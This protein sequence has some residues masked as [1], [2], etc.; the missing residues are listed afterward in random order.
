MIPV[1]SLELQNFALSTD[2]QHIAWLKIDC[3]GSAVNRL[4]ADVLQELARV[5][6]YL[7][8]QVPNGLV[9]YSGKPAGFIAGADI[10]E[11]AELDN[12]QKGQALVTRG[13]RLFNKLAKLPYPTLALIQGHCLGGGLE[14]ALACR[15]RLVVDVP[16]TRL[17]LPEVILGIFPG[18]G[19]MMRLPRLIGP[20]AAIDLMLSG[21]AVDARKAV[22]LGLADARVPTRLAMQ[23][24]A[25]HVLS[26]KPARKAR[27]IPALLNQT[28][29]RPLV[30]RQVSKQIDRRDPY[31]HY[32]APR[33]I[34]D[35]WAKHNGNALKAPELIERL[36]QSDTAQNLLRVFHL[37]ERLKSI[38]K[39]TTAADIA[40]LHVV[41]AG[42]MGGDIAALCALKGMTVTLQ[43]QDRDRIAQAQGRAAVLFQRRLKDRRLIQAALDRLIPD[44]EGHGVPHADLVLEAIFENIDAKQ[45][46]YA[47]L[48]PRLKPGAILATNTS[49]LSLTELGRSLLQPDRLVGIHFFNPVARMP[50]VEVV[51]STR[52]APDVRSAAYAFVHQIG[53]LP[54]PV[55]DSPGFLVNAV[56]APYMLEAMRCVDEG[57]SPATVDKAMEQFGMPMG[58]LELADTVGLDIAR[59]AGMQLSADTPLPTCLKQHLDHQEL[60]RKSGQGFYTWKDG[61]ARKPDAATVPPE[62]AERLIRPLIAKTREQVHIGVVSDEDLADAGVI[63]GTGFAP[64]LGGPLHYKAA[65]KQH[66]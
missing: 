27:G 3:A 30:A 33:A 54:L 43:D 51:E 35:V 9:I 13:W 45:A 18:W 58:P 40:R 32:L 47:A 6:D 17:A 63:F 61:K 4:S 65:Q 28:W 66:S 8:S 23:A 57:L 14:L 26:G 62:L 16:D 34:L 41:G 53:K 5:L 25:Q 1:A 20:A 37:Q 10:D 55:K 60:G 29:L 11:F 56:L 19:G 59:D 44:P 38:G 42:V 39:R 21:K 52:L 36:T 12:A 49:S 46:L 48:E 50:L 7:N 24:A 64:F 31:H 22:S 2:E 15:Y